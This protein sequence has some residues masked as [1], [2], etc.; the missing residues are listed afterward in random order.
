MQPDEK[1]EYER[2][3]KEAWRNKQKAIVNSSYEPTILEKAKQFLEQMEVPDSAVLFNNEEFQGC[4]S[5][6]DKKSISVFL[7]NLKARRKREAQEESK[8]Q[9]QER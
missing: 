3:K 6:D 1:K 7:S 5:S 8:R 9:D 2:R 4:L